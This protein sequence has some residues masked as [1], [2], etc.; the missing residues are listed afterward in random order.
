MGQIGTA[1]TYLAA[2]RAEEAKAEIL[3]GRLDL[4]GGLESQHI[5]DF[6]ELPDVPRSTLLVKGVLEGSGKSIPLVDLRMKLG[7]APEGATDAA[8]ALIVDL[9]GAE[10]GLILDPGPEA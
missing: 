4:I 9:R 6:M 8:S 5:L 7:A 3:A 2:V 1:E 10:I